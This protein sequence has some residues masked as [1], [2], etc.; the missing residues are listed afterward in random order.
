MS[1]NRFFNPFRNFFQIC[2]CIS[3]KT[4]CIIYR[5]IYCQY[6]LTI[7]RIIMNCDNKTFFIY[8]TNNIIPDH[9]IQIIPPTLTNWISIDPSSE[10]RA[11]VA[12][13]VVDEAGFI[14]AILAAETERIIVTVFR[15]FHRAERC[16]GIV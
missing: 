14:I 4:M 13:V 8:F 1:L 9:H 6:N 11:V 10:F 16:I 15:I 5:Y 7:F 12:V 2:F 3:F